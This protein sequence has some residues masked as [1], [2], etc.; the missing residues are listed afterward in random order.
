MGA[1]S[2]TSVRIP[3]AMEMYGSETRPV[4]NR[5]ALRTGQPRSHKHRMAHNGGWYNR[6]G[7]RLGWGDL[8]ES[9]V[10]RISA[11][12]DQDELFIVT[13]QHAAYH[14]FANRFEMVTGRPPEDWEIKAPGR[15][16]IQAQARLVIGAGTLW[17]ISD[18]PLD[19]DTRR[20]GVLVIAA[21]LRPD[22]APRM[23]DD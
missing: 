14:D 7:H 6:F 5:F 10:G 16:Y 15:Q 2:A 23:G 19:M 8:D 20:Q 22:L 9:D 17:R 12:L 21:L 3:L 18:H 4:P 1:T 13:D 11:G